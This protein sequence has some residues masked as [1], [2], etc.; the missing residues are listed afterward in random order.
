LDSA[1][2]RKI[3]DNPRHVHTGELL[4]LQI[5][6]KEG[7][8]TADAQQLAAGSSSEPVIPR[9]PAPLGG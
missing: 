3:D 6:R 9:F 8:R 7:M 1:K 2:F 5:A 4:A